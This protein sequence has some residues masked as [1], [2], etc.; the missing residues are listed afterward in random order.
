MLQH[1][2][3]STHNSRRH[4]VGI[5]VIRRQQSG[6]L[7]P[8]VTVGSVLEH[9]P[10]PIHIYHRPEAGVPAVSCAFPATGPLCCLGARRQREAAPRFLGAPVFRSLAGHS[11]VT[12]LLP[13]A[14]RVSHPP[15][16]RL[17]AVLSMHVPQPLGSPRQRR[18]IAPPSPR[19][20]TPT[21]SS[22]RATQELHF[23]CNG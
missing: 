10:Y 21:R 2:S 13:F 14:V 12:K 17:R 1:P 3:C 9:L 18:R 23:S 11:A 16:R 15:V 19:S 8:Y 22:H 5:P 6:R 7:P 20:P 4:K